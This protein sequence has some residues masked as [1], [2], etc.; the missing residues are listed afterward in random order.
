MTG[1]QS[2][3]EAC[4]VKTRNSD[5]KNALISTVAIL[6]ALA[7]VGA[8]HAATTGTITITGSVAAK[9]SVTTFSDS[10]AIG[11]LAGTNGQLD[12]TL[13][14]TSAAS[15][16]FTKDFT[17]FCT[18]SNADISVTS[19]AMTASVAAPP[20]GYTKTVNFTS[21]AAFN[22]VHATSAATTV[23]VDDLSSVAG[24]TTGTFGGGYFLK[25]DA[26]ANVHVSAYAFTTGG[27]DILVADPTYTGSIVVALTPH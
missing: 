17:L 23:T 6:G 9:C 7:L 11:E 2:T 27:T 20:A 26:T 22:L 13:A 16:K 1:A 15:P 8:A 25:N 3:K 24:A 14:A 19:A 21:R 10:A 5:I 18:G 4:A 12:A